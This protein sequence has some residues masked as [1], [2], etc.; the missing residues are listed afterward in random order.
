MKAA[1]TIT[2]IRP[3]RESDLAEICEIVNYFI[4]NTWVNFRTRLQEVGEWRD[5]WHRCREKYPWLT[6]EREGRV[7]GFAYS[8]PFKQREAYDRSVEVTVYVAKDFHRCGVGRTL[9][10]QLIPTLDQL[11][12]HTNIAVIGL[13]NGPSVGLH[14]AFGFKHAGTLKDAGFKMAGWHDVGFW[15]RMS[16]VDIRP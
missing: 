1:P 16:P 12:F 10:E 13:P 14:E 4:A 15:Q 6:A 9:Y 11:K 2:E 8:A 7:A 3:V 5:E